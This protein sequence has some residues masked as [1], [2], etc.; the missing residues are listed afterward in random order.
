VYPK[1]PGENERG[2]ENY[3]MINTV[4]NRQGAEKLDIYPSSALG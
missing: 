1:L 2:S 3:S 4:E